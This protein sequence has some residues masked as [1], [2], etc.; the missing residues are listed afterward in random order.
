MP[1]ERRNTKKLELIIKNLETNIELLKEEL[2][3]DGVE[4]TIKL[5][6]FL[7]NLDEQLD[8]SD[9]HYEDDN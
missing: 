9:Y 4:N 8:E 5:D 7:Q 2:E 1:P 6:E 3:L